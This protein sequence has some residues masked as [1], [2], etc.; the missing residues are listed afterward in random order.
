MV[1]CAKTMYNKHDKGVL[2]SIVTSKGHDNSQDKRTD[3]IENTQTDA[4]FPN[5]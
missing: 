1:D 3:P 5:N 2:R 4:G